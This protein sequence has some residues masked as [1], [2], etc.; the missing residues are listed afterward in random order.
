MLD[1]RQ[2][3]LYDAWCQL[4]TERESLPLRRDFDPIQFPRALSTLVLAEVMDDG[5]LCYR[6]VGTDIPA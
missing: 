2:T 4:A 5:A 6:L 1:P 3:T